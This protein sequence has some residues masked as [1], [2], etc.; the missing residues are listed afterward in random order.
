MCCFVFSFV[1]FS[2][3]TLPLKYILCNHFP[4]PVSPDFLVFPIGFFRAIISPSLSAPGEQLVQGPH[5]HSVVALV[6][7]VG[8]GPQFWSY[9]FLYLYQFFS[10]WTYFFT[11]KMVATHF[12]STLIVCKATQCHISNTTDHRTIMI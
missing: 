6:L 9:L 7:L 3:S 12:S 11:L 4:H 1:S 8:S 2:L 5:I 10:C